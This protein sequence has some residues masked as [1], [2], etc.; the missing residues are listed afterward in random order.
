[1][2]KITKSEFYGTN[3]KQINSWKHLNLLFKHISPTNDPK[4]AI[5]IP[6]IFPQEVW[7]STRG[8]SLSDSTNSLSPTMIESIIMSLLA[9][10][11]RPKKSRME[12]CRSP[13]SPG[14]WL[15]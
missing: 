7:I 8:I 5:I 1:M 11:A 12:V 6:I 9:T 15:K 3:L 13:L 2:F 10:G 4:I 14:A